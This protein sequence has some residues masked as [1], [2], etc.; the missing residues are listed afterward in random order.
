MD[1]FLSNVAAEVILIHRRNEFSALD[2]VEKIQSLK[3]NNKIKLFTP[4]EVINLEGK[5]FL[6]AVSILHGQQRK[7]IKVDYFIP[8]FGLTPKLGPIADW[9]LEIEKTQ[10][11]LIIV[12]IIKQT[13]LESM[14]LVM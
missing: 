5:N 13:F 12:L 14:L 10:L 7:I 4:A 8:L 2:S 6:E 3:N 1:Y 9:G 11:K